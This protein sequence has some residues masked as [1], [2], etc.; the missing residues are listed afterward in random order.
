MHGAEA[1]VRRRWFGCCAVAVVVVGVVGGWAL[2]TTAPGLS[3]VWM[4]DFAVYRAGGAAVL[5]GR[6][7]Y[8]VEVDAADIASGLPFTYPPFAALLFTVPALL[9]A[10]VA[11]AAWLVLDLVALAGVVRVSLSMAGLR[12]RLPW[13]VSAVVAVAAHALDPVLSNTVLGQ[14]NVLLVL[15]VLV[16]LHPAVPARWSGVAIGLAAAVKLTPLLFVGY[17]W[18]TG[19]RVAAAWAVGTVVA[20]IALGFAVLPGD[21]A[22]YWLDGLFL[23]SGRVLVDE[24]G[25]NH[26]LFGLFARLTGDPGSAWPALPVCAAVAGVGLVV[27]AAA[28]QRGDELAG[29]VLVGCTAALVSPVTWPPHLVWVVPALVWLVA[30]DSTRA[31]VAALVVALWCGLPVYWAAQRLPDGSGLWY[32]ATPVGNL[33]ATFGSP[34]PLV[35]AAVLV[36][37]L[38]LPIA[39]RG[40]ARG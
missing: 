10:A 6:P 21:S 35:V 28:R 2:R 37:A 32:Q 11:Q 36:A 39:T 38:R 40:R 14:V 15:L 18:F 31:A 22:R 13:A 33:L 1:V 23:D 9:G 7:L 12:P 3:F 34:L 17:L 8:A 20:T 24:V 25:V 19:R 4:A 16:G 5:D 27:A 30:A 26:S 29:A